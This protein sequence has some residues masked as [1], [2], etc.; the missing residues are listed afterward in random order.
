MTEKPRVLIT[1]AAGSIGSAL[2]ERLVDYEVIGLDREDGPGV[3][4]FDITDSASIER[5]LDRI[6]DRH[7]RRFAAVI[8]LAAY[9]DFSG[10]DNPLYDEVNVEGTAK[11]LDALQDYEVERFIYSGTM[12]VHRPGAPGLPINEATAIDPKWA[13]PISKA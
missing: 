10:E 3:F 9:F 7:G 2:R 13:Y 11:L 1:G 4:A 8:H 12:L 6:A 5:A